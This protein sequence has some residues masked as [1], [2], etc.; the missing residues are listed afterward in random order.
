MC[1]AFFVY[2]IIVNHGIQKAYLFCFNSVVTHS[3]YESSTY[4]IDYVAGVFTS[5][6][7]LL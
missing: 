3:F 2:K 7:L 6:I 1:R 4:E 5:N